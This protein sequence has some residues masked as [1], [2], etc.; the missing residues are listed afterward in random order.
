MFSKKATR[1]SQ[2]STKT[3]VTRLLI[4]RTGVRRSDYFER[5]LLEISRVFTL[6]MFCPDLD[7]PRPASVTFLIIQPDEFQSFPLDLEEK[8]NIPPVT[9]HPLPS[10]A[11]ALAKEIRTAIYYDY[12]LGFLDF[13]H[14]AEILNS[15]ARPF[16]P[17]WSDKEDFFGPRHVQYLRE[18]CHHS[19][20]VPHEVDVCII[21]LDYIFD[22]Y[23]EYSLIALTSCSQLDKLMRVMLW[24]QKPERERG[25][26][27]LTNFDF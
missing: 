19:F 15:F 27:P 11:A 21:T 13:P 7:W 24:L 10:D 16:A 23:P 12:S 14:Y 2:T 9:F 5:P 8:E 6:D 26:F 3:T 25:E 22:N 18:S 17:Y 1:A 4:N 20:D